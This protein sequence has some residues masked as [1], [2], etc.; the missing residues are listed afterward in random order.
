MRITL[1]TSNQARH[2]S[3]INGLADIADEVFAVQECNTVF[4]GERKDF[5]DSSPIMR[6]YFARLMQAEKALFANIAFTRPNVRTLSLKPGDVSC[7]DLGILEPALH[8]DYYIV[9]GASFIRQPLI[10]AL[11]EQRALNIHMG[12]SPYYR[13]SSTNFWAMY[14]G[15]YHMNCATIHM[16]SK[17]LDSGDIL[18]HALPAPGAYEPFE[19]GMNA[20]KAAH[21]AVIQRIKD[22]TIF[23]CEPVPQDRSKELRYTRNS[24]FNDDVAR[25]Y[26]ERLPT[27]DMI[28]KTL[29]ARDDSL[30]IL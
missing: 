14:D 6:D 2:I 17:G 29:N 7:V 9:F 18:F 27:P 8:S 10:D 12:A 3:F 5:F 15:N 11:V 4:P 20:V 16:L 21:Q 26:L 23:K 25:E 24:D 19:L 30:F 1:F 13:G 22:G 28:E